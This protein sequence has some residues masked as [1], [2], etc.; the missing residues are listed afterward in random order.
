MEVDS[1]VISE[2]KKL[3]SATFGIPCKDLYNSDFKP[4]EFREHIGL[5]NNNIYTNFWELVEL[6]FFKDNAK[7]LLH[8]G[9]FELL[10]ANGEDDMIEYLL[11]NQLIPQNI[12]EKVS[13]KIINL[14][15]K[16]MLVFLY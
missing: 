6:P 8:N 13:F 15:L 10:C 4:K 9:L 2:E 7:E 5:L 1:N 3:P 11:K 16:F 12:K 14:N